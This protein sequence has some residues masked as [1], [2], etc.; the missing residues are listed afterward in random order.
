MLLRRFLALTLLFLAAVSA[1]AEHFSPSFSYVVAAR[2]VSPGTILTEGD[3][4]VK[5]FP[6]PLGMMAT[7]ASTAD[8]T[9]RVV[10]S[11]LAKGDLVQDHA[12]L[13]SEL[14]SAFAGNGTS[15]VPIKLADPAVAEL[16]TPGA[17]VSVVAAAPGR[18]DNG[19]PHIVADNAR[20]VFASRKATDATEAGTVLLS[21]DE[22]AAGRVAAASLDSPLTITMRRAGATTSH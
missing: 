8:L 10:A 16:A 21:L 6:Q 11:P 2:D 12:V 7:H 3:L 9:G 14:S 20:V 19:Q 4:A 17:A 15:L 22:A 18:I 1:L 13:G 5:S